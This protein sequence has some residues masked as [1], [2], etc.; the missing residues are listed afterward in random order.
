MNSILPV[1]LISGMILIAVWVLLRFFVTS[2]EHLGPFRRIIRLIRRAIEGDWRQVLYDIYLKLR[3]IDVGIVLP[4]D[5]GL[6]S[7]SVNAHENSGGPNLDLVLKTISI[8]K[9][10]SILDIGCGKGGAL[11]TL[12]KYRFQAVD[13]L[14]ISDNLLSIAKT[15]LKK[16]NIGRVRLYNSNAITFTDLDN[17]TFIYMFNPFPCSIMKAVISNLNI[18][19]KQKPREITIIYKS[20]V[21]HDV[22]VSDSEFRIAIKFDNFK[23]PFW[24]YKNL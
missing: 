6:S 24:I 7:D 9:N 1:S 20:P 21:C 14:E 17:Y 10:D 3:R 16:L 15:N 13:G 22:I 11:I 5:L 2:A 19:I 12:S 18:S 8:K 4:E 23:I